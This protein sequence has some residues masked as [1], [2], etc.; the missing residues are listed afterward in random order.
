MV[1]LSGS[2]AQADTGSDEFAVLP[3]GARPASLAFLTVYTSGGTTGVLRIGPGGLLQATGA[4]APY[5]TSLA[6]VSFPAAAVSQQPLTLQNGWQSANGQWGTGDPAYSV[7][8]GVVHLSGSLTG[9]QSTSW[10][11]A[12]LP[13]PARPDNCFLTDVYALGGAVGTMEVDDTGS[14]LMGAG[15]DPTA[16]TEFTSLAG[17]SYPAAPAAWTPLPMIDGWQ[18]GSC[19]SASYD[20]LNNTVYLRGDLSP[21]PASGDWFTQ[22]PP[23]ARPD[24]TM[25]LTVF[26]PGAQTASLLVTPD[27]SMYVFDEPDPEFGIS[28][29]GLSFHAG[30]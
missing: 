2:L 22:L 6:G 3:P 25:Y 21:G 18:T 7:T 5:F 12:V 30:S 26:G 15:G 8:G 13:S 17:L 20:I 27:G 4:Q 1:Y 29:G 24:H 28:L 19:A 9:L 11:A 23:A 10:N 14:L 16:G